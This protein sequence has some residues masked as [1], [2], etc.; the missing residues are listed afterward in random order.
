M[1]EP[2]YYSPAEEFAGRDFTAKELKI[3]PADSFT[4]G[5]KEYAASKPA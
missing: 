3:E 5:G 4:I 2:N 1:K